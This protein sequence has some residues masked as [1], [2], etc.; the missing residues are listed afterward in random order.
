[1]LRKNVG[2]QSFMRE[3]LHCPFFALALLSASQPLS[4][5]DFYVSPTGGNVAPFT[6][7]PIAATN[8]Q[9]AIDLASAGDVVWVTNGT[10]FFGGKT[11]GVGASRVAL[12]KAL[13]VQSVNGPLFTIVEG[14][15]EPGTTNGTSAVRCAW[16]TNG[17][18]LSGFT[19]R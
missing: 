13:T 6:D 16:L 14:K 15:W 8:I 7:W 17:A 4:G 11:N 2:A 19:L 10:Y 1:M 3:F 9:D 5:A 18:T 12:D